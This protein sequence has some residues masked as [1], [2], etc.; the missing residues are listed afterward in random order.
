MEHA[1]KHH[2]SAKMGE[3]PAYYRKLSQR[4]EDILQRFQDDWDELVEQLRLLTD[5]RVEKGL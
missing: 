4:L 5:Q 1:A 2:I 3:D